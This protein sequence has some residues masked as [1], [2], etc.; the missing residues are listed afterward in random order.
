MT[1]HAVE[2]NSIRNICYEWQDYLIMRLDDILK[3][4][5]SARVYSEIAFGLLE[6]AVE[7]TICRIPARWKYDC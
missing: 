4:S 6:Y 3:D 2:I 5:S 1:Y 7:Q